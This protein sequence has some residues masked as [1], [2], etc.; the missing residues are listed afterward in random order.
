MHNNQL[1]LSETVFIAIMATAMGIAWWMYS[2]IYDILSPILKTFGLSGLLEGFWHM[3]GIFFAYIIRKPGSAL[4]GETIAATVEGMIS[5][6]GLSALFSGLAQGLPVEL[7]FLATRYKIWN[8]F[9]CAV[10]GMLSALGGYIITYFWYGYGAFSLSFNLL[11][12]S[13]NMLSG[14]LLGGLFA[15]YLANRLASSGVLN[16]FRIS[17]QT[18]S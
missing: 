2:L 9:N 3:G 12:L 8:K 14:A 10:A 4:L 13:C 6:W 17:Q 1:K 5:Q 18:L 11:N 7:L 16:Q 15:R